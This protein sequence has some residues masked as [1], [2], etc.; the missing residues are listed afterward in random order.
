M[1]RGRKR[2]W[3]KLNNGRGVAAGAFESKLKEIYPQIAE[4]FLT[5]PDSIELILF[6]TSNNAALDVEV[7]VK[8]ILGPL[9]ERLSL[10]IQIEQ[11]EWINSRKGSIDRAACH[12]ILIQKYLLCRSLSSVLQ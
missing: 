6:N 1:F 2:D 8:S 12:Q 10:A 9:S 3:F 5:T 7:E 4:C 11:S